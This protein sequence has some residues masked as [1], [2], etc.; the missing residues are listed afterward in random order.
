MQ[1]AEL[2]IATPDGPMSAFVCAP[3]DGGPRP[4]VLLL[5]EA[6]GLTSHIRDVAR[7]I[8]AEGYVVVAPD[9][10]HREP[11][12]RTFGYDEVEQGLAAMYRLDFKGGVERDLRAAL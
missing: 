11:G 1:Q 5:M 8:A 4:G 9:L 7:R 6:F 2:T 10:Y 12:Q 3:P